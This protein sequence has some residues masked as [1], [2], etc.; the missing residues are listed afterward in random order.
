MPLA[1]IVLA[2][3][4]GKRMSSALPKVLHP[5]GGRPLLAYVLEAARA[6]K[7]QQILVVHGHRSDE[8]RAAFNGARVGWVE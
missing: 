4:Q 7:P 3:G 5:L 8:L 6:L 1:V 2:A